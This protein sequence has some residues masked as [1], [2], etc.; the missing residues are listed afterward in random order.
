[1]ANFVLSSPILVTLMTEAL[2][3]SKTS[4]LAK[5]TWCNIPEDGILHTVVKFVLGLLHHVVLGDVANVT[6]VYV[7]S[8]FW[9][10]HYYYYW[11]IALCWGLADFQFLNPLHSQ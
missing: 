1:M 5:A 2:S 10:N 3:S 8:I 9:I 11:S 6:K 7:V 4:V